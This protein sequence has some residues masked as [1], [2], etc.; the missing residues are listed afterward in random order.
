MWV[1]VCDGRLQRPDGRERAWSWNAAV[2]GGGGENV[3][4]FFCLPLVECYAGCST[5]YSRSMECKAR[6]EMG[7]D[8]VV[9]LR[10]RSFS[11]DSDIECSS[12]PMSAGEGR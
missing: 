6:A 5:V 11:S 2:E 4:G 10:A 3:C 9:A 8:V 1:G 12:T 7:F